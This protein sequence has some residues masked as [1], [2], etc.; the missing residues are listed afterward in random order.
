MIQGWSLS[1]AKPGLDS[2]IR[3][4]IEAN[5]GAAKARLR[6]LEA[7]RDALAG[8]AARRQQILDPKPALARLQR[9]ADVLASGNVTLGNLELGR[10]I[11][12]IDAY[13]DGSV[14]LRTTKLGVFEGAV[15]LLSRPEGAPVARPA[16]DT[17]RV[18]PRR[19]GRLRV[20]GPLPD[21]SGLV[22]NPEPGLDPGRFSG[23]GPEWFWEDLLEIPR[24][25]FWSAD[26]ADEVLRFRQEHPEWTMV[27]LCAYFGKT[28]PTI[29]KALRIA[30][31]RGNDSPPTPL[32]PDDMSTSA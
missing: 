12:R 5:Y 21:G 7:A 17:K 1:L 23:L 32:S 11:D 18:K 19:R 16:S 2:A 27:Q 13:P 3:E 6:E 9:L 31:E 8:Q 4:D 10:H 28:S 29:R 22:S 15:A 20:D 24:P 26:H 14:V 30:A 25:T